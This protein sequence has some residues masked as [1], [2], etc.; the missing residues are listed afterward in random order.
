MSDKQCIIVN[1]VAL[2]SGGALTILKQ[3]INNIPSI[4]PEWIIFISKDVHITSVLPNVNIIPIEGTKSKYKRFW[5]DVLGLKRWLKRNHIKP[6]GAISL[7]NT[8]FSVGEEVPS[9]IYY[10]QSL[11]FFSNNWN[12]L[13]AEQRN[14]WFYKNIYPIF[15]RLFLRKNTKI[16]VQLDFIKNGFSKYFHHPEDQIK[17]Y[18][19]TVITPVINNNVFLKST[20]LELLYPAMPYF[21]KNHRVIQKALELTKQECRVL[22]TVTPKVHLYQDSRI[23]C[24]GQQSYDKI[25]LLYHKCDALLFPSYIETFGL[26]L[27]EAAMVGMPIIAADLPYAREVLA[28][29]EGVTF[30]KYDNPQE[31]AN[32]ISKLEKGKRYRPLDISH[33]PSWKELFEEIL[34]EINTDDYL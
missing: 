28:G 22:F 24:I 13:K 26:P 34:L 5:W 32:V 20:S 2:N 10:H 23:N 17:V 27:L 1:A 3:F 33:R 16:F 9:F 30:V 8:G 4:S 25:S 18:S 14:F 11:P 6:I 29:Y 21:Y 31:W 15:V 12:P 7:Q 19:P